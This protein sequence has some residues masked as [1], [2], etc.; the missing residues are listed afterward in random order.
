LTG[1]LENVA[2]AEAAR[3]LLPPE[4]E[5]AFMATEIGEETIVPDAGS[6]AAGGREGEAAA[7]S[8]AATPPGALTGSDSG[9]GSNNWVVGPSKSATGH[10]IL[11]TDPHQPFA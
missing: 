3:R 10:P 6:A 2:L 4:L 7:A 9:E 11:C 1:R 8:L 5:A